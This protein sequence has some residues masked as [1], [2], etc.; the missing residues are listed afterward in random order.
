MS[1]ND[2]IWTDEKVARLQVLLREGHSRAEIG[3]RLGVSKDAVTSKTHRLGVPLQ[4]SPIRR[5]VKNK[6]RPLRRPTSTLPPL[7]S[8]QEPS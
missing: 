5:D 6:R 3:R 4:P 1:A 7:T 8:L 2:T